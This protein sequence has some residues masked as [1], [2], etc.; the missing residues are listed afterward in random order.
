MR[1]GKS[2]RAPPS[3][4]EL[5]L[6]LPLKEFQCW[7]DWRWSFLVLSR[8][9][10]ERFLFL[11]FL[12][13][14]RSMAWCPPL[15]ARVLRATQSFRSSGTKPLLMVGLP[16]SLTWSDISWLR[17]SLSM[18]VQWLQ[19]SLDGKSNGSGIACAFLKRKCW[20]DSSKKWTPQSMPELLTIAL[21]KREF[22][23]SHSPYALDDQ[24]GQRTELNWNEMNWTFQTPHLGRRRRPVLAL[25]ASE[26]WLSSKQTCPGWSPLWLNFPKIRGLWT[27]VL[28]V[29]P[30]Q[31]KHWD[32]SPVI[33]VYWFRERK[34]LVQKKISLRF[35]FLKWNHHV[36]K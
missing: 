21:G 20:M 4:S 34:K 6:V 13:S 11:P 7:S 30:S 33:P 26:L 14:R 19:C 27:L 17:N 2:I 1:S 10:V 12:S 16:S 28:R 18:P 35:F 31:M 8:K 29:C 9:V 3:L 24:I 22:L 5:S 36:E 32:G 23:L 15:C 25:Y